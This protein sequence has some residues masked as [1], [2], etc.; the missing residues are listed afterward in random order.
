MMPR[1]SRPPFCLPRPLLI[2][3]IGELIVERGGVVNIS[4][5]RNDA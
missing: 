4:I 3:A 2:A 1:C 5:G